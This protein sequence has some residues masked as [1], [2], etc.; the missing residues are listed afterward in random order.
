MKRN[1]RKR[2]RSVN[3]ITRRNK[4]DVRLIMII[5]L[6]MLTALIIYIIY[7]ALVYGPEIAKMKSNYIIHL[8]K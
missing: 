2:R 6:T 4:R 7:F 5:Y 1:I 3:V 8:T